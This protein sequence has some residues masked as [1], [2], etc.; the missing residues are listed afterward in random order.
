MAD[1][2][3][4]SALEKMSSPEQLDKAIVIVSP[5]FWLAMLGAAVIILAALLWSIFGTLPLNV[6]ANG[7]FMNRSGIHSVY[8]EMAGT[9]ETIEIDTGLQ[10]H[11]GEVIARL[12]SKE[13][14]RRLSDLTA[15]RQAVEDV[16]LTSVMDKATDD[17]KGL[18]NL[19]SSNHTMDS[20]IVSDE[21]LLSS[22]K[23]KLEAQRVKAAAAKTALEEVEVKY[24]LTLLPVDTN[25]ANLTY[26]E[27]QN[28]LET[29]QSNLNSAKDALFEL[30]AENG[31][32]E[33]KYDKA[34]KRYKEAEEGTDEYETLKQEYEEAKQDWED[35]QNEA[36]EYSHRIGSWES[37]LYQMSAQHEAAKNEQ[38]SS[39]VQNESMQAYNAQV[40]AAY[41]RALSDYNTELSQ[42]RELEDEVLQI[43]ARMEGEE[44]EVRKSNLVLAE[45]FDS[46]KSAV[47]TQLDR[48]IRECNE[49]ISKNSIRSTLEGTITELSIVEGQ[50]IAVGDYVA[51]VSSGD[52]E[53][54]VVVCYVPVADGRKIKKGMSAS[55]YPSTANKQE[56]GH[57]RGT[58]AYVD[59]YVT[60]RAEITN[61][62]GVV[63][64]VDSFLQNGPVVEVR[65]EL[66]RDDSTESGYW[67]S[68]KKGNEIE[69]VKGTM[70]AADISIE[71]KQPISMLV[72]YL[73]EKLT[74]KQ[75]E[76][77]TDNG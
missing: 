44:D 76:E 40:S 6:S 8:S 75:A 48:E 35:Y 67:W 46:E 32:T 58:V 18:L 60:S 56:Y 23:G 57:M 66:E 69:L 25:K 12:S 17:N 61:Q 14:E 21:Y 4:K 9:V 45:Q 70:V 72:P 34:K 20:S 52:Q 74:I 15:R 54:N 22:R 33:E 11:K 7:I 10:V 31:N 30:N 5:S 37:V 64:L 43:E 50:V 55:V 39:V 49:E 28:N 62:V 65:L 77:N 19:K 73:K 13:S 42:V 27:V 36:E 24:Y 51:R 3:R 16:T 26:E 29:A 47:L 38:V 53:D 63:S 71:E 2:Y 68:S 59:E 41:E 1:I